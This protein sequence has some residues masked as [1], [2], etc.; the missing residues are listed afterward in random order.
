MSSRVDGPPLLVAFL[1]RRAPQASVLVLLGAVLGASV[2]GLGVVRGSAEQAILDSVRADLGH[3][4]YALQTGDPDAIKVLRTVKGITPVQDQMGDVITDGLAMPLLVRATTGSSL[5]LGIVTRGER[6]DQVGEVLLSEPAAE[7]MG[8]SIGDTVEVRTGDVERPGRVVGFSVDPAN[9]ATSTLIQIVDYSPE[10]QP[11]MWLSDADFYVDSDLKPV[12][13]GR[14]AVYRSVEALLQTAAENRPRFLS[15]LGSFPAGCGLLIGVLLIS[16]GVVLFRRWRTDVDS[17]VAAGMAPA[18][19]WRRIRTVAFGCVLVGEILGGGVVTVVLYLLRGPVS[20]WVGQRWTGVAIP[21]QE[22]VSVL[23]LTA[24]SALLAVPAVGFAAR[25][26]MRLTPRPIQRTWATKLAVLVAIAGI[27][28]WVVLVRASHHP[29]GERAAVLAPLAAVLVAAAAPF[30]IASMLCWGLP[31]ATRSL[32]RHLVASL[33][34]VAAAGAV[35]AFLSSTW[36][37]QTTH[38]ANVGE[39]KTSPLVPSGSFVISRMPDTA[40]PALTELYRAHGGNDVGRFRIPDESSM[41]LRVTGETV[42]SCMSEQHI[43]D[44]VA[45]QSCFPREAISPINTVLLDEIGSTPRAD[46]HLLEDGKV[47]L[48][49]FNSDD[50]TTSRIAVTT[51]KGDPMLGGNLPGL[52]VPL[53]SDVAE[54]FGLV[55]DGT[56][57]VALLDFSRLAPHDQ[58]VIRAAAIRL[59]PGAE[60]ASGTDPTAY[61]RLRSAANTVSFLGA[62]GAT[63]IVLLG[64][65]SLVVAHSLTRRALIDVGS[66]SGARWRIVVRWT[67]VPVVTLALTTPLAILTAS[68][69]GQATN[70][71]Y[72]ILWILPGILGAAAS[73]VV[74]VAFLRTPQTTSE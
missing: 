47:G 44:P 26:S 73:L 6:P 21:W 71:S 27:V 55:P 16:V 69:G 14:V 36:S 49:L 33:R 8:I 53:D 39:A 3:Q 11:T 35:L 17:L 41:R 30:V 18:L 50:G 23:G 2:I 74:G 57:E 25:Q 22:P 43:K 58:F 24:L 19:A 1:R 7:S 62:A 48:L 63:M 13:D 59:A 64:G 72:G 56:S 52:V 9:R 10:F 42:I 12:L 29:G 61:D 5:K 32:L 46:P 20:S 28:V 37:A 60:T 45:V 34:S 15:V 70:A 51:A 66:A 4:S 68:L 65:L 40:I 38:D 67:A 54:E 31:T